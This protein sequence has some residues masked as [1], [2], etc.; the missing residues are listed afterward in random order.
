MLGLTS[1]LIYLSKAT[2]IKFRNDF[3][4]S[5]LA[6]DL[7]PNALQ[8]QSGHIESKAHCKGRKR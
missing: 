1:M 5:A 6:T 4:Q 2:S 7:L 8:Q 3:S